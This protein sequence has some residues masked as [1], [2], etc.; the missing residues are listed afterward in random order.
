VLC[1]SKG[2]R[3]LVIDSLAG[4]VRN[5]YNTKL[6]NDMIERTK[7]LFSL[8]ETLKWLSDVYKLCIVVVNQVLVVYNSH[9]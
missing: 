9:I 8:A 6:K 2:I 1:R 4:L 5:E 7:V 3:L